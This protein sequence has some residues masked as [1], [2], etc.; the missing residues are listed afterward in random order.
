MKKPLSLYITFNAK[1]ASMKS[2]SMCF[3]GVKCSKKCK[4]KVKFDQ[5][6][7]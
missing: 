1:S 2:D 3:V 6:K 5:E 4:V 7:G